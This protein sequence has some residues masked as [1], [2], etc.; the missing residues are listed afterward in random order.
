MDWGCGGAC[1]RTR[2]RTAAKW[3]G[4]KKRN[5]RSDRK[6]RSIIHTSLPDTA[7]CAAVVA[8]GRHNGEGGCPARL[9]VERCDI[10][11]VQVQPDAPLSRG[12]CRKV[13]FLLLQDR[14]H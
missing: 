1:P 8:D 7:G 11:K 12:C 13:F 10:I 3:P 2:V 4:R 9:G 14:H 5:G 6:P